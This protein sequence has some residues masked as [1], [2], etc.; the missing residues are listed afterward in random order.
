VQAQSERPKSFFDHVKL[1]G[2]IQAQYEH[3][4][5][6]E[7]QLQ[8]G[9]ALLNQNRFLIRRARLSADGEWKFASVVL[10]LDGNT[11]HGPAFGLQRAEASLAWRGGR[12]APAPPLVELT[13]GLFYN[14]FGYEIT[15]P[16]Q[17]RPFM[18]RSRASLAF[19]PSEPD[20][21]ARVSGSYSV[22]RYS[23]AVVNGE[24]K[25]ELSG[26]QLQDPNGAK[27]ILG[28]VGVDV[29]VSDTLRVAGGVS[30]LN[31][32][33]F[34]PGTDNTKNTVIW[35]DLNEDGQVN[36]GELEG[37]PGTS[38]TVSQNYKRWALGADLQVHVKTDLGW[39]MLYGEVSAGSNMDRGLYVAD[40]VLTSVDARELGYY[41]GFVQHV[42]PHGLVGFRYDYY[43]PN[44]DFFDR[45][46][47]KLQPS[48][49]EIRTYSPLVGVE[50]PHRA[51]LVFEYDFIR[52]YFALDSS[53]VPADLR[54]DTWTLRLQGEL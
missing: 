42:G 33:G 21:G 1:G 46:G 15:E 22:F 7:D 28:R 54:N 11:I 3:H 48:T 9:G 52:D 23:V 43:D 14:P 51:R 44:A 26:Y 16:S 18:E 45:E 20:V 38:G 47:G 30:L 13:F 19:F 41:V 2:F 12:D 24:P 6:S 8:Q 10:E 31:G 53:G 49:E 4:Q 35:T 32:T 17:D 27:D 50:L 34:H 36:L 29:P 39:S 40:P 25:G 37:M 5:D